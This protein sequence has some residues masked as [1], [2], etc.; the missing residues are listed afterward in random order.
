MDQSEAVF[1]E[2]SVLCARLLRRPQLLFKAPGPARLR[3]GPGAEAVKLSGHGYAH[4]SLHWRQDAHPGAGH[5]EG[6]SFGVPLEGFFRVLRF[7]GEWGE[8]GR[9]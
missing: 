7:L 5:L 4:H 1:A 8:M 6:G 9:T 3:H 2:P